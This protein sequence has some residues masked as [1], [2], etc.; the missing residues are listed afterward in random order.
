MTTPTTAAA[1][2]LVRRLDAAIEAPDDG[3]RCQQ[4]RGA[5]EWGAERADEILTEDLA[6]PI[7]GHY[8]RRLLH[9]DPDGRYCAVLMVWGAG[10]DTP[11][12]DHGGSWC[13]ECVYRGRIRVDSY[14]RTANRCSTT[15]VWD[16]EK[17]QTIHAGIGESGALIPPFEYHVIANDEAD[18]AVTLHVYGG[19]MSECTKFEPV[20]GGGFQA[21]T[22]QLGYTD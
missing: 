6:R 9:E 12:H 16:F 1:S 7:E 13:V 2:E 5:L 14:D 22:C 15:G 20:D 19:T 21:V 3:T 18:T 8:A 17:K 10:Q 4:V 11:L